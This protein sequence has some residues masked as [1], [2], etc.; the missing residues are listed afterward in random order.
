[1]TT[2]KPSLHSLQLDLATANR[3]VREVMEQNERLKEENKTAH[4]RGFAEAMRIAE[5]L[6]KIIQIQA[7]LTAS[8]T[9]AY[10]AGRKS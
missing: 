6:A 8:W 5:A 1:M 2:K 10:N 4:D 7:A 9:A 3:E